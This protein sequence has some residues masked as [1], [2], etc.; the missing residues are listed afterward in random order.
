MSLSSADSE[1][2]RALFDDLKARVRGNA[3]LAESAQRMAEGLYDWAMGAI[4][5]ARVFAVVRFSELP[6][7]QRAFVDRLLAA[8][9]IAGAAVAGS[10][11]VLCLVGTR[12]AEADWSRI[13]SS[14]GHLAIPLLGPQFVASIPMVARLL[15]D[16]GVAVQGVEGRAALLASRT[17]GTLSSVFYVEDAANARDDLGRNVIAD[18]Q[19]VRAHEVRS[20]FASGGAFMMEKSF[21]VVLIVARAHVPR[22]AAERFAPLASILKTATMGLVEAGHIFAA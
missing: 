9:N 11:P 6:A 22:A 15:K 20:V 14:R 7:L 3:S 21:A 8:R 5:L 13:E 2:M 18:Q 16:L 19:F 1:G 17:P 10:T 12:G 4:V